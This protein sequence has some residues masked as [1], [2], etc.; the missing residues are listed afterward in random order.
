MEWIE[1]RMEDDWWEE[2]DKENQMM[3]FDM[4]IDDD[5]WYIGDNGESFDSDQVAVMVHEFLKTFRPDDHVIFDV[6]YYCDKPRPDE[7]G[8]FSCL[9]TAKEHMWFDPS[10][11]A[12]KWLESGT[13]EPN[14]VDMRDNIDRLGEAVGK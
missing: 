13:C 12:R 2:N 11:M 9:V 8:G 1:P 6:A 14:I 10:S 5:K 4:S 7:F 3:M